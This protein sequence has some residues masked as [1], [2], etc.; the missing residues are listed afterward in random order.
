[1]TCT[2]GEANPAAIIMWYVGG[3]LKQNGTDKNFSFR[4]TNVDHDKRIYCKTYNTQPPDYIE[5]AKP[6]LFVKGKTVTCTKKLFVV[7]CQIKYGNPTWNTHGR[8]KE[9]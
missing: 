4:P 5:S 1:M 7:Q 6:K 2:P 8:F 9:I 3:N